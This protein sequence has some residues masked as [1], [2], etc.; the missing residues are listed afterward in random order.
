MT[1]CMHQ[2]D[3]EKYVLLQ[4]DSTFIQTDYDCHCSNVWDDRWLSAF[5]NC[6]SRINLECEIL[7]CFPLQAYTQF[8]T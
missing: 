7:F 3:G 2:E 1:P 4:S 5:V 6:T 8:L